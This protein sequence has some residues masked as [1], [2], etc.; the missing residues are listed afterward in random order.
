MQKKKK[1]SNNAT[2]N[3]LIF[4]IYEQLMELNIKKKKNPT[5]PIKKWAEALNKHL[6]KEDTNAWKDAQHP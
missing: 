3:G 2:D 5:N 4:K 6:S 1:I